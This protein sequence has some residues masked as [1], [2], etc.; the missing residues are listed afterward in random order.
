MFTLAVCTN[1]KLVQSAINIS[2]VYTADEGVPTKLSI[3]FCLLIG[4]T[5]LFSVSTPDPRPQTPDPTVSQEQ[6]N[7]LVNQVKFLG[8]A[9]AFATSVT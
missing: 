5:K 3:E 2:F 6:K 4:S 9:H 8:L 7:D 1:L